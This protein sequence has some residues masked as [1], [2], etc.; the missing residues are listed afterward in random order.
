MVMVFAVLVAGG[1]IGFLRY[2]LINA[3]VFMGEIGSTFLGL[4]LAISTVA[5]SNSIE[6][7]VVEKAVPLLI[8]CVPVF[9]VAFLSFVRLRKGMSPLT[10]SRDHVVHRL[11]AYGY[12]KLRAVGYLCGATLALSSIAFAAVHLETMGALAVF[13]VV[14]IAGLMATKF[15]L[16]AP[17]SARSEDGRQE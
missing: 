7:N 2:N 4:I 5:L 16:A 10:G 15:L 6:G 12:T 8:I 11:L 3:S 13:A 14:G 17:M 9:E 1:C